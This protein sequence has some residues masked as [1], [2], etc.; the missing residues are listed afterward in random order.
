MLLVQSKLKPRV[1]LIEKFIN[2][3]S[4]LREQENFDSLMAILAG[5]SCQPIFRLSETM[6][7]VNFKVEGDRQVSPKRLRSLNKLMASSKSFGAYRLAL[8]NSGAY[9]IPYLGVHLQEL[10]LINEV[11][12]SSNEDGFVNWTKFQQMSRSSAIVLDCSRSTPQLPIDENI[13]ALIQTDVLDI[14]VMKKIDPVLA[15]LRFESI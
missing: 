11:K 15:I 14:E 9:I 13:Q 2:I 4:R 8:A 3:A 6:E 5:L 7:A 1:R 12:K 10:T